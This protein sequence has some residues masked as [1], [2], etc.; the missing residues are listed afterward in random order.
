MIN[1]RVRTGFS[2]RSAFGKL[3]DVLACATGDVAPITDT[4]STFAH[5]R[6]AKAAEKINKRPIFGL[7]LTVVESEAQEKQPLTMVTF[8]ARDSVHPLYDLFNRATNNQFRGIPRLTWDMVNGADGVFALLGDH[9]RFDLCRSKSA[10]M[11]VHPG[12]PRAVLEAALEAG[13]PIVAGSDNRYPTY[14][15]R[16]AYEVIIGKG[17]LSQTYPQHILGE[18]EWNIAW[19]KE[20][21]AREA[22]AETYRIADL[23][24]AVLPKASI[25]R[26]ERAATIEELCIEGAVKVGVDLGD[27]VYRARLDRELSIIKE[28]NF[29]DY[30]Y[31]INDLMAFARE[32]MF[33]GP[34]RGSSAGS[35]I[36]YLLGITSVDPIRFDLIFERF[37]DLNRTDYPDVDIDLNDEQR[38]EVFEYLTRKYG[39]DHVA[40]LG[41]IMMYKSAST[42]N[43]VAGALRIDKWD[44]ENWKNSI[45]DRD[46]GDVRVHRCIEDSFTTSLGAETLKRFPEFEIA[47]KIEGHPRHASQHA[48]GVVIT[49]EPVASHVAIDASIN[50]TQCEMRDAESIGLLKIDCLGLTQLGI[51]D[52]ALKMI[53][54]DR[55]WLETYPLDDAETFEFFNKGHLTGISQ[56]NG[57]ALK[58]MTKQVHVTEFEDLVALTSLARPGPMQSGGSAAWIRRKNGESD[59]SYHHPTLEPILN[60]TLGCVIY[61]EQVMRICREIGDMDW[62]DVSA[63][64]KAMGKSLGPEYMHKW[65]DKFVAGAVGHGWNEESARSY[66]DLMCEN[67]A[68]L[69]NRSHAVAY[70]LMSY[71][72]AALKR[73]FPA[74]FSAATMSTIDD[75]EKVIELLRDLDLEGIGFTPIDVNLST[76]R[77]T[78]KDGRL[79]G[80]LSGIGGLGPV[81]VKE[82]LEARDD[83]GAKKQE[84]SKRIQKLLENPKTDY[85]TLWPIKAAFPKLYSD[86]LETYNLMKPL[87]NIGTLTD[88][89][90]RR[91]VLVVGEIVKITERDKNDAFN[92]K[93]RNGARFDGQSKYLS[94]KI[95]DDTGEINVNIGVKKYIELAPTFSKVDL[96]KRPVYVFYGSIGPGYR[97]IHLDITKPI[98]DLNNEA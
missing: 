35:L 83:A 16:A 17:H 91:R 18:D 30:F 36:C 33:C 52:N 77:W 79:L 88:R 47:I 89:E 6:W 43:E 42:I 98:G 39:R 20:P 29:E 14:L 62:P 67:G 87:V 85:D 55:R 51:F 73:R 22:I 92:L 59:V 15:D 31:I 48:A 38:D 90:E 13:L 74:E 1:L 32:R 93:K 82:I 94:L 19:G 97:M 60:K 95:V 86:P 64:R 84:L 2:F 24:R 4:A 34:G 57:P 65:S 61:Q 96:K 26:P 49:A 25:Y 66:W 68:Y 11:I 45:E 78:V 37:I 40:R 28:K 58:G 5:I 8:L 46:E 7:E 53:S 76:D 72:C 41:T 71:W 54:K 70:S 3:P 75:K 80:P 81:G 12:T 63:V 27:P 69:F 23:C 9:P 10:A 21:W 50:A 56:F 44:V